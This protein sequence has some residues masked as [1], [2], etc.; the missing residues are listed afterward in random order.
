MKTPGSRQN[1]LRPTTHKHTHTRALRSVRIYPAY[2]SLLLC[3]ISYPHLNKVPCALCCT[4]TFPLLPPLLLVCSLSFQPPPPYLTLFDDR[5][6]LVMPPLSIHF[7]P[8]LCLPSFLLSS[9]WGG[10]QAT[11]HREAQAPFSDTSQLYTPPSSLCFFFPAN[12][13]PPITTL[14]HHAASSLVLIS[15]FYLN[16]F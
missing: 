3:I 14:S 9:Y 11:F 6:N 10:R 15:S 7:L 13:C 2:I 8:S 16:D 5:A 12:K 4:L 1:T